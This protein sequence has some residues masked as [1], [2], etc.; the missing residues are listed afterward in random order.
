MDNTKVPYNSC[1]L[2]GW[3]AKP[4]QVLLA[5]E[6]WATSQAGIRGDQG[7]INTHHPRKR[8]LKATVLDQD[9]HQNCPGSTEIVWD[10]AETTQNECLPGHQM[11]LWRPPAHLLCVDMCALRVHLCPEVWREKPEISPA[12][13]NSNRFV[14][15]KTMATV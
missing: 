8:E 14:I 4:F 12:A 11:V 7:Q 2:A 3:L 6:R 13:F 1:S 10:S 5:L 9:T 15:R